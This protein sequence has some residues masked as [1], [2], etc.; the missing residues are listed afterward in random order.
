MLEKEATL[1]EGTEGFQVVWP[2][3]KKVPPGDDVD[4][5]PSKKAKG[6]QPARYWGDIGIKLGGLI[7]V[8]D[9]CTP[10]SPAWCTIWG[11]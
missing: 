3:H 2:K 11:E 5:Q 1:L 10:G 8:K 6:K 4:Y 9:V 7:S